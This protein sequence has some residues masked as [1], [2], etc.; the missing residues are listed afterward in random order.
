MLVSIVDYAAVSQIEIMAQ[1]DTGKFI[2]E[3]IRSLLYAS[4]WI[5]CFIRSKRV[6]NTF[7][8]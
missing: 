7:V 3:L 8:N 1:G 6:R 2:S 5:P 4:I